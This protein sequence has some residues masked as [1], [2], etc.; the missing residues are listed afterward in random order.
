MK[1]IS[2]SY[3]FVISLSAL[4]TIWIPSKRWSYI[5]EKLVEIIIDYLE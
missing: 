3:E 2:Y 4:G 5:T 1:V